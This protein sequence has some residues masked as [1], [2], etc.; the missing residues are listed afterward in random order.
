MEGRNV[1]GRVGRGRRGKVVWRV[2]M[3]RMGGWECGG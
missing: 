1:F 3:W 2:R